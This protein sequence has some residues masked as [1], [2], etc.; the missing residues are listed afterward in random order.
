M[1]FVVRTLLL[2]CVSLAAAARTPVWAQTANPDPTAQVYLQELQPVLADAQSSLA[3][4]QYY[5]P[6][7]SPNDPNDPTWGLAQQAADAVRAD[8]DLLETFSP[9]DS[10]TAANEALIAALDA[11][12]D[13]ADATIAALSGGDTATG[14]TATAAFSDALAA[15]TRAAALLPASAPIPSPAP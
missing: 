15:V 7:A 11:A 10:L 1:R 14:E 9:P 8:A 12:S 2:I 6:L 4:L 5:L 3:D 13:G